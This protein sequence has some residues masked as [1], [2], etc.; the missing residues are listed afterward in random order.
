MVS[1]VQLGI[2]RILVTGYV[3]PRDPSL[4]AVGGTRG[5]FKKAIRT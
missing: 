3:V 1:A 4:T 5:I 2:K